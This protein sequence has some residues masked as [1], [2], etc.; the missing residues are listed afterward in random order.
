MVENC[1]HN[2]TLDQKRVTTVTA[3][4][5]VIIARDNAPSPDT[6]CMKQNFQIPNRKPEIGNIAI[7]INSATTRPKMHQMTPFSI[8]FLRDTYVTQ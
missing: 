5:K 2:P 4:L 1:T 6:T 3:N 7:L 8:G